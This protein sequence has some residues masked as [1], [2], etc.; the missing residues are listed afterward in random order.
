MA[1]TAGEIILA[2]R[3]PHV[4]AFLQRELMRAGLQVRTAATYAEMEALIRAAGPDVLV[5]AP[6][7]PDG[8]CLRVLRRL[9]ESHPDLPVVVHVLDA[10]EAPVPLPGR[11]RVVAKTAAMEPLLAA[12]T[13]LLPPARAASDDPAQATPASRPTP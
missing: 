12:V 8:D 7:L 5:L 4:R 11:V 10:S 1:Q 13:A 3:N 6:D 9:A 2:D